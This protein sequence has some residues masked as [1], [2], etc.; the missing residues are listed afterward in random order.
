VA[1]DLTQHEA[2]YRVLGFNDEQTVCDFC[3]R[4]HLKATV[5]LE[6]TS[7]G[8][9]GTIVRVGTSCAVRATAVPGV[10]TRA[11]L[12]R[13]VAAAATEIRELQ[14]RH[15]TAVQVLAAPAR[16][17]RNWVSALNAPFGPNYRSTTYTLADERARWTANRDAAA[18]ELARRGLAA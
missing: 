8:N 12:D 1:V 5:I 14:H 17:H 13:H 18:A 4:D 3:G 2:R 9:E 6:D 7:E 16:L 11:Q 10:R 15:D